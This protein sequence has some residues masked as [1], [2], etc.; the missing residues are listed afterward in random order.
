RRDEKAGYQAHIKSLEERVNRLDKLVGQVPD[1]LIEE[2]KQ[3]LIEGKPAKADA[4]FKQVEEQ[5]D[6]HIMAAAEV[7]Y[8]RGKLAEDAIS[9]SEAFSHYKRA[10]QLNPDD[11]AY[12]NTAGQ[13]ARTLADHD[14]AIEYFELA[15]ASDLK[16]FGEDHPNVAVDRNNLGLAWKSLGEYDKAIEYFELALASDLKTYGEDHPKVAI[17]RNNLG[18]VWRALGQYEKAIGLYEQAL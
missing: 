7:A 18:E 2:A 14:K 13:M 5:T 3:A 12:L 11:T 4:L 17:R 16:T 6:P 1:K 15:L 10:A 8:Q 9:Y